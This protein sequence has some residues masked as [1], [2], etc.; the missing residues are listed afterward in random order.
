MK[1]FSIKLESDDNKFKEIVTFEMPPEGWARALRFLQATERLRSTRFVQDEMGG[2]ISVTLS[3]ERGLSSCARDIDE[4]AVGNMLMKI[5]PFIL[6]NDPDVNF[7]NIISLLS[8]YVAHSP[9]RGELKSF[10]TVFRLQGMQFAEYFGALG[11]PPMTIDE[12]MAWLNAVE[13]HPDPEK[14]RTVVQELGL[15]GRDRNGLPVA[16]YAVVEML[17]AILALSDFIETLAEFNNSE[18]PVI[19]PAQWLQEGGA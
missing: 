9:L 5:R 1:Q 11:R 13:Y 10:A 16:L 2:S 12:V 8:R 3:A 15:F 19:V 18:N 4:D 17:K 14:R 7:H 6:Q